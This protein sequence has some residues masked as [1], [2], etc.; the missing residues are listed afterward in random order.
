MRVRLERTG[1]FANIRRT[2]TADAAT[3]APE[4]AEELRRLVE[5]ADLDRVAST[6]PAPPRGADRFVYTVTVEQE[7]TE[8]AVTVGEDVAPPALQVLIDWLQ[9]L[10]EG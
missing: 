7:G 8:R 2:F 6:P 5:A 10:Q 4:R 3:L 9:G 1:G